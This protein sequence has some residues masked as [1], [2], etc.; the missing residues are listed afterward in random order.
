VRK[1]RGWGAIVGLATGVSCIEE[2]RGEGV[3][4]REG[5]RRDLQCLLTSKVFDAVVEE[6]EGEVDVVD[7]CA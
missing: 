6:G 5:C 3:G 2:G 4:K 7:R 1:A